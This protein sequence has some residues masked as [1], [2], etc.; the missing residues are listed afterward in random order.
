MHPV[1]N[2]LVQLEE[3]ILIRDEQKVTSGEAHLDTL[4]LAIKNMTVKLPRDIREHAEKLNNKGQSAI[5]PIAEKVCSGCGITLPISLVQAVRL[6]REVHSC[7]SCARMLYFMES[8][9]KRLANKRRRTGPQKAGVAR[10]SSPALMIP[11]LQSDTVEGVIQEMA[12]K[13]EAEGFLDGTDMLIEAALQREAI[14]STGIDNGMAIPHVRG[15]EGGGLALALGISPKGIQWD[16]DD[17]ELKHVIFFIVIPTAA[18]AFYLKL[19]A[20]LAETFTDSEARSA[21]LAEST[22]DGLYKTL[23]KVTR[24][25]IK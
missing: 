22:A 21:I 17:T 9:P 19:L 18:S 2:H 6:A 5:V 8:A 20:G 4:N 13:M 3:L 7:P 16:P 23:C 15:V 12:T 1:V 14:L 11:A 10:F 25:T 24:R